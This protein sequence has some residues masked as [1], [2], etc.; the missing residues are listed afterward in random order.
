MLTRLGDPQVDRHARMS[1]APG[2]RAA[3][4]AHAL[5]LVEPGQGPRQRSRAGGGRDQVQ[6]LDAVGLAA[7]R[8]GELDT[9]ARAGALA[10]ARDQRRPDGDRLRE[11]DPRCRALGCSRLQRREH[12]C[13]ELGAEPAHAT[14][15][16]GKGGLAQRLGRIDAELQ[17]EQPRALGAQ[18]RYAG[19][20]DQPRR[21]LRAQPL[22]RGYGARVQQRHDLL[23]QRGSDARKLGGAAR[24]S[25]RRHR[26]RGLTHA[27]GGGAVG[28][29]PMHD[30]AIELVQV[31]KLLERVGDDGVR[32][33]GR[34]HDPSG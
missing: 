32:E 29:D 14:Q 30:R 17:L 5:D 13:L 15:A 9:R 26:D 24:A 12:V 18:P 2:T 27:L 8:S 11:Q 21:E 31:S 16:L 33:L 4:C 10:Q 6:V 22:G 23:L 3:G 1:T 34:G 25:E 19:D 7:D 28:D 20:R